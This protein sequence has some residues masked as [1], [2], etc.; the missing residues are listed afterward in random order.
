MGKINPDEQK[1]K[2]FLR[3]HPVPA[4]MHAKASTR[5]KEER[6]KER[7]KKTTSYS[8]NRQDSETMENHRRLLFT[9]P[10]PLALQTGTSGRLKAGR[11]R[12]VAES[13]RGL[14]GGSALAAGVSDAAK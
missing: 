1:N 5:K 2:S 12:H 9:C 14:S 4:G 8:Q 10:F 6:T 3:K 7:K 13:P 11:I